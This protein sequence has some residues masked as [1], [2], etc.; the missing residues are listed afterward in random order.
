MELIIREKSE[1]P[2]ICLNMIVKNEAHIIEKTLENICD[3][4]S[5]TY[6]VISD[7]GSDDDTKEIIQKFFK[8]KGIQGE[9]HNDEW[10]NFGYNRTIA[11]QH[12]LNKSDYL[13]IFDADDYIHG[14]F[15]LPSLTMDSY[16]FKFGN[17]FTYKRPL[18][19]N[20]KLKWCYIGVLH[21][22]LSCAS[23]TS[24]TIIEGEY[25]VDSRRTGGRHKDPECYKKDAEILEKAYWEELSDKNIELA[26]RY[27]FYCAQSYKDIGNTDKALQ[28]YKEH[29]QHNGWNQ[30]KFC[31]Y[32]QIGTILTNQKNIQD[33][34]DAYMSG[35]QICPERSET[36]YEL[37][38]YYREKGNFELANIYYQVGHTIP[39]D[40]N[41]LFC[42]QDIY[43]YL[44]DYE[45]FVFFYYIKNK[46]LY[47]PDK[48][49]KIFYKLLNK[50]Y[51]IENILSNYKFYILHLNQVGKII[52]L[53]IETEN[54]FVS[55]TPS[56]VK[57]LDTYYI[58]IRQTN[59][60]LKHS[61]YHVQHKNE[62][63]TN[64]IIKTD[65][66]FN[67]IEKYDIE[68]NN[69]L[70]EVDNP[71]KLFYGIQDIRLHYIN[72]TL[73]Y[74]G[75]ISSMVNKEK[76]IQ[77]CYGEYDISNTILTK[78]ILKS[79]N[80]RTCEKNWVL[81]NT[82]NTLYCIYEWY[83]LTIGIIEENQLLIKKTIS[84]SPLFKLIRGSSCG[85]TLIDEKEI[86]FVCHIVS[87]EKERHYI[88]L[89][90]ILDSDTFEV[91]S[92]SWPFKFENTP[93][94]YCLGLVVQE[95]DIIMSY[96]TND[97][98][99]KIVVYDRKL[100]KKISPSLL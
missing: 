5:L 29:V 98:T 34:H 37:C 96:S 42:I 56:L 41:S 82:S 49:H 77:M 69:H 15:I 12:A 89:I 79:P 59:V 90:V 31:S 26:R 87:H 63:T 3:N 71:D 83:P 95:N 73:H 21:E 27:A 85:Y 86:W 13:F 52:S 38:K 6:W 2:T 33:A 88:H 48:I 30:E 32:L 62:V 61:T 53:D 35:Y 4:I 14:S 28:Y 10:Q 93:V 92:I 51:I 45:Y 19:I 40:K 16:D 17:S 58:N 23:K 46:E 100:L 65:L 99:S 47:P 44:F 7:T 81:F 94:E 74:I 91:K 1:I 43:E 84:T 64:K 97:A 72:D 68:P 78:T 11:L 60:L 39:F 70:I 9:I 50:S 20:N 22:Y 66:S 67:T 8:K 57:Y 75:T 54:G 25:Y 55:S 80:N 76:I 24:S 36:L 18:L